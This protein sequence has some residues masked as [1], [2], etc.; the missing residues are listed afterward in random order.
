MFVVAQLKES[1][2]AG[3]NW[4]GKLDIASSWVSQEKLFNDHQTSVNVVILY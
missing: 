4:R 1:N 3:Q 2:Y